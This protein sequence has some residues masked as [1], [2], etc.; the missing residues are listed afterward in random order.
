MGVLVCHYYPGAMLS[1]RRPPRPGALLAATTDAVRC[2]VRLRRLA[3]QHGCNLIH[4]N[5]LKTHLLCVLLAGMTRLP[6]LVHLHDIPNQRAERVIWRLIART[7]SQVI[8]VSRPCYPD[9]TLPRNVAV[10]RNGITMSSKALPPLGGVGRLRLAFIGRFHP[11]KGL[12]R[13]LDWFGAVRG[14]GIDATLTIRGRP[15]A[16][17]VG[18]WDRIKQRIDHEGLA[19]FV[20]QEGW[21]TGDDTYANID[22]LLLPSQAPDPAPLVISEAMSAGVVV[23]AFP[24]GGIPDMI[25]NG[26]TGLLV[27]DGLA[28]VGGLQS[29]QADPAALGRVRAAAKREV[30][31]GGSLDAFYG[32]IE[33]IYRKMLGSPTTS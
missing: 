28:L 17:N 6:T 29:F 24:T 12:D 18:Y 22:V 23:A 15:D 7:V 16:D 2:A 20:L 5:G 33:C 1:V 10:V 3:Q 27:T 32:R 14:A 30:D 8:L 26:R 11:A 19:P 13:L 4:S 21:V 25:D 9:A 31:E